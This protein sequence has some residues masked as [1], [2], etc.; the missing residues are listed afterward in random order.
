MADSDFLDFIFPKPLAIKAHRKTMRF[1]ISAYAES[2][3]P[4]N[5]TGHPHAGEWQEKPGDS[6][7]SDPPVSEVEGTT[8]SDKDEFLSWSKQ[9]MDKIPGGGAGFRLNNVNGKW[10]LDWKYQTGLPMQTHDLPSALG[11]ALAAG[12]EK[13]NGEYARK[14][15]PAILKALGIK[16]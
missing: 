8:G 1:G 13:K 7:A 5:P 2:D 10:Y 3:H 6:P 14:R 16:A 12:W 4:R 15:M 11:E 9:V